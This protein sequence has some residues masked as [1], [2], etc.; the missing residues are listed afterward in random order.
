[1]FATFAAVALTVLAGTVSASA[2]EIADYAADP[3]VL[4]AK[5]KVEQ[6]S[7][8]SVAGDRIRIEKEGTSRSCP[9]LDPQGL[10]KGGH[11]ERRAAERP[12]PGR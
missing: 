7:K 3:V 4:G 6:E 2:Q 11:A 5:G 12:L 9:F 10:Q 1:M 8:L